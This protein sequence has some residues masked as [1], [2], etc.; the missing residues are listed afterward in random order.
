MAMPPAYHESLPYIDPEPSQEALAAAR[1]LIAAEQ[2]TFSP[3]PPQEHPQEPSFSP[4]IATELARIASSTPSQPLDLSRYEAQELPPP[5]TKTS[6]RSSKKSSSKSASSSS[7]AEASRQPLSNAF[8]SSSYLS[9]RAQNLSLL[10]SHGRNAWLLSNY[11]LEAELR[12][13]ERDLAATKRDMD[14]LN[15]ARASRQN[16]VKAEMQGLEQNWREGVGRVLETEIA[17][18]ELREQIRQELRSRA[19]AAEHPAAL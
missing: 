19:S 13:L 9:S 16:D 7:A 14:L 3:P 5:P 17:V 15:A 18:Q 12:S 8:I 4:A 6:T 2:S 11:H 10:D 1:A